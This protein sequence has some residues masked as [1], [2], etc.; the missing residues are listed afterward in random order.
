MTRETRE[1]VRPGGAHGA[2]GGGPEVRS[3]VVV[4]AAGTGLAGAEGRVSVS[5]VLSL[6]GG[7][8]V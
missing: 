4:M 8:S 6:V 2:P 7:R 3:V 1:R 5:W